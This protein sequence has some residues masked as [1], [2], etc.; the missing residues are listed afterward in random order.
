[1]HVRLRPA[2]DAAAPAPL[3]GPA[4]P[5]TY[6]LGEFAVGEQVQGGLCLFLPLKNPAQMGALLELLHVRKPQI[7][8]ALADLHYVHFARF[9]PT[10]D[11]STLLVV[12]EYDG[13]L[14]PYIMD[15]AVALGDEF[16]AILDFVRDAPRLPV[17]A[18]PND[19]W[20]FIESHNVPVQPWSAYPQTTVIDIIRARRAR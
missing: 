16:T 1:M 20:R 10:P 6:D 13:E 3:A 7:E 5:S 4:P 17:Q 15:F 14:K 2:V 18:Y 8:R 19:F 11:F 9:I 12:T